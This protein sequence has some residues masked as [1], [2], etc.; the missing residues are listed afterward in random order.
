MT[1][2][3]QSEVEVAEESRYVIDRDWFEARGL[4]FEDVV[5]ERIC[6]QCRGRLG[7][8]VEERYTAFDKKSGRMSFDLRKVP[9]GQNPVKVIRECCG[10]K[11]GYITPD[12]PTLEAI[13]RIYLANGNQP[14]P[15]EHV[16]DQLAEWCPGG[17]CQWLMLPMVTLVRLVEH[18]GHYGLR[19]HDVAS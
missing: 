9:Y 14:M 7:E 17:G 15:L 5:L 16:R 3:E 12:M 6:D 13:F 2:E 18:D 19:R 1:V 4:S 11:K 8:T 10:K